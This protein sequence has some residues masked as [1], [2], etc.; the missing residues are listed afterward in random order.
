[1]TIWIWWLSRSTW[2][3]IFHLLSPCGVIF[4]P[5]IPCKGEQIGTEH[6]CI[7]F[8]VSSFLHGIPG[9]V[10][11]QSC[12]RSRNTFSLRWHTKDAVSACWV[13]CHGL[14]R[15]YIPVH[16]PPTRLL[17]CCPFSLSEDAV[18]FSPPLKHW[19]HWLTSGWESH[20][21]K[22]TLRVNAAWPESFIQTSQLMQG[23][24]IVRHCHWSKGEN[25]F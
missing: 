19:P 14:M 9:N 6:L 2:G 25:S 20:N 8:S 17:V 21:T 13:K 12:L 22:N 18:I 16:K 5:L 1:M 24:F 15:D 4:F 23:T 7:S 10:L 11:N 3:C